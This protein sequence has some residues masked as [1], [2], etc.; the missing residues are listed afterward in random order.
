[1]E[2]RAFLTGATFAFATLPSC[3]TDPIESLDEDDEQ[4]PDAAEIERSIRNNRT[5][6]LNVVVRDAGDDPIPDA[7]V[8]VAMQSH[9]FRFGTA[10]NALHL[11]RET[12]AGD[13]YRHHLLDLF[14]TAVLENRHKWRLWEDASE[15]TLADEATEWLL[16]RGLDVRG[17]T[18]IWQD[19]DSGAVPAD[20]EEKFRSTDSDRSEYLKERTTKHVW[21]IVHG[22]DGQVIEWDVLNEHLDYH[23]ITEAIAPE[24]PPQESPPVVGWFKTAAKASSDSDLY[25]NDFDV[26]TG[27]DERLE[28]LDTLLAYLREWDAPID[29]IGLQ[30]HFGSRDDAV[31]PK[32]LRGVLDRYASF[33]INIQI[34]EYD[35]F[36]SEW[37][38]EAEA[39]HLEWVLKTLFSHPA[40]VG[41]TMWGFW[42]GKHWQDNAPLFRA[43]WSKKP[44]YDVYTDLVF[45]EWWT[46]ETGRTGRDGRYTTRAV[47]G[48]Y[49]ITVRQGDSSKTIQT[50]LTDPSGETV[51]VRLE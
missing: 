2:R 47:L 24:H 22:Y 18:A 15:R 11:L 46:D 44:A 26:I 45:D 40:A 20:V 19:F 25:Y 5:T 13:P 12:A 41:F 39:T 4:P 7:R 37:T 42:D 16:E 30:G 31:D 29:G 8:T 14:N 3:I 50:K 1:M 36:G 21:E 32:T 9:D 48:K 10:V 33:D 6:E 27:D 34:T 49:E 35:T 38:E 17:H 43:D 28:E 23:Q 51:V